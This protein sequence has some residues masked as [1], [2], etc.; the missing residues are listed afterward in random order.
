MRQPPPMDKTSSF[1]AFL[2]LFTMDGMDPREKLIGL[3]TETND[4]RVVLLQVSVRE[5][6]V[7]VRLPQKKWRCF[8]LEKI[9]GN[10]NLIKCGAEVYGVCP[11][12]SFS[13]HDGRATLSSAAYT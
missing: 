2:C 13:F 9:L 10:K 8:K 1:I 5:R 7:V 4:R 11:F 3:D 6:C 12:L